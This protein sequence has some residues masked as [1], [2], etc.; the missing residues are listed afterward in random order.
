MSLLVS[1]NEAARARGTGRGP[2]L[3]RISSGQHLPHADSETWRR[4][5][6]QPVLRP[7]LVHTGVKPEFFSG[8]NPEVFLHPDGAC[9]EALRNAIRGKVKALPRPA[10]ADPK[11]MQHIDTD[12]HMRRSYLTTPL[13][14]KGG[15]TGG[16][17]GGAASSSSLRGGGGGSGDDASTLRTLPEPL[18]AA[19]GS[20]RMP[21]PIEDEFSV[22]DSSLGSGSHAD[23]IGGGKKPTRR[24]GGTAAPRR[25]KKPFSTASLFDCMLDLQ[26]RNLKHRVMLARKHRSYPPHSWLLDLVPRLALAQYGATKETHDA[27][28]DGSCGWDVKQVIGSLEAR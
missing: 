23:R 15:G 11:N 8:K 26:V 19:A 9:S 5:M 1:A 24:K 22:T 17:N 6:I 14:Y 27:A 3:D 16:P 2:Y 12:R 7:S 18:P 10:V 13:D 20:V 25:L 28:A 4:A 21:P